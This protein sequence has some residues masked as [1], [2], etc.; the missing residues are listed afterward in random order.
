M[1]RF[2]T[3]I[4]AGLGAINYAPYMQGA[5]A[6]SQS[7]AQ[8]IASLGQAASGAIN[9]YYAKKEEEDKKEKATSAFIKTIEANP[10][11]FQTYFK[12]GN[13]DKEAVKAVVDTLGF[14]G[15][16]QLNTYLAEAAK[17]QKAEKTKGDAARYADFLTTQSAPTAGEPEFMSNL[18]NFRE[19]Q[20]FAG[21]SPE[22]RRAGKTM[23][24]EQQIGQAQ[25]GKTLAETQ[26]LLNP[27]PK[28]PNNEA[29]QI[30]REAEAFTLQTG[31][32]P[33]AIEFAQIG[34]RVRQQNSAQTNI[35]VG[36]RGAINALNTLAERKFVKQSEKIND[37]INQANSLKVM[38]SLLNSG[39][40]DK[41]GR[42]VKDN[43]I[44]TGWLAGTER[45]VKSALNK[46]GIAN[47]KDVAATD[48]YLNAAYKQLAA[49]VQ[50]FGSGTAI[51]DADLKTAEKIVA[52][53]VSVEASALREMIK[54]YK[55]EIAD[56]IKRFNNSVET[57]FTST[58]PEIENTASFY[59]N[60]FVVPET[61]YQYFL[62][63][64]AGGGMFDQQGN[65]LG[66]GG[67]NAALESGEYEIVNGRVVRKKK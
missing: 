42:V 1:A 7:I 29:A 51:S 66:E 8:G 64:G 52:G 59:R 15:T 54:N 67:K 47:F 49:A 48:I 4:Q 36:E 27:T 62:S 39:V 45:D 3:G 63:T 32:K 65:A 44:I 43:Q 34:A 6:G 56:Q 23:A 37:Y 18:R 2:G 61:D 38:E 16:L 5:V 26:S 30:Q 57:T 21:L 46:I 17:Q 60:A 58:S 33:N 31:R 19:N 24:L 14:Q 50:A 55:K 10:A 12:D 13:V 41:N 9:T 11:A 20:E 40:V 22:A 25:L 53:N 28:E 35:N